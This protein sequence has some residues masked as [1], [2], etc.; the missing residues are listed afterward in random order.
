MLISQRV[1]ATFYCVDFHLD[2]KYP[3]ISDRIRSDRFNN[4][5][6][7][8]ISSSVSEVEFKKNYVYSI[9]QTLMFSL[10][11]ILHFFPSL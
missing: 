10:L 2:H 4:I 8:I 6:Y 3:I 5:S 11:V 1:D 9:L 7:D